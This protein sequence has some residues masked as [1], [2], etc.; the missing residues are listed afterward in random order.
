MKEVGDEK[1]LG[2]KLD[3]PHS[4]GSTVG[5]VHIRDLTAALKYEYKKLN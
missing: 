1:R 4:G 3:K 2:S 5:A